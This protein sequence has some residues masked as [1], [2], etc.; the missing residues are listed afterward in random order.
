MALTLLARRS[1]LWWNTMESASVNPTVL[2]V[3]DEAQMRRLIRACLEGAGYRVE[4]A[5]TGGE[6]IA[7]AIQVQPGLV[8]LDLGL[9]DMDGML[10]LHRLREWTNVPIIILSVRDNDDD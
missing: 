4:E 1:N 2:V 3:D 5:A 6:G 9:P 8:I 7:A 10:V